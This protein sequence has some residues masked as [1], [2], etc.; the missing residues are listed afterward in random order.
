MSRVLEAPELDLIQYQQ[1]RADAISDAVEESL[2]SATGLH[3]SYMA[4]REDRM[5][6]MTN[7]AEIFKTAHDP[8]ECAHLVREFKLS[9]EWYAKNVITGGVSH[10]LN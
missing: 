10:E 7:L 1:K 4:M 6:F 3:N 2:T 5:L 8:V 9:M